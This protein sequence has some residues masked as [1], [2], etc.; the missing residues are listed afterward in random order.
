MTKSGV[1]SLVPSNGIE[2][3]AHLRGK[4]LRFIML[5]RGQKGIDK[6][7]TVA[8]LKEQIREAAGVAEKEDMSGDF[9]AMSWLDQLLEDNPESFDSLFATN[10]AELSEDKIMLIIAY[11]KSL[12]EEPTANKGEI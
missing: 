10:W 6:E 7:N 12:A 2:K 5:V 9:N 8:T 1:L 3:N 4:V 11:I